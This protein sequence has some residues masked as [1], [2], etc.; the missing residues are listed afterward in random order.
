V[1]VDVGFVWEKPSVWSGSIPHFILY[2]HLLVFYVVLYASFGRFH[3]SSGLI[4]FQ[5]TSTYFG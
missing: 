2:Q 4:S 5:T 1:N 3:R